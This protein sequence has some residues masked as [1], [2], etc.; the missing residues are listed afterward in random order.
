MGCGGDIAAG[1][2]QTGVLNQKG[3]R[4][5]GWN[6]CLHQCLARQ[7]DAAHSGVFMHVTQD[8]RQLQRLAK[9]DGKSPRGR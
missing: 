9:L 5:I 2:P 4:D 3:R 7:I 8:V 1:Q 6:A